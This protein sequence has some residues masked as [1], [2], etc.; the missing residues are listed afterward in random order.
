MFILC[1][2]MHTRRVL[3]ITLIALCAT[4]ASASATDFIVNTVTSDWPDRLRGD[5]Y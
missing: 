4:A 3:I 1:G 2:G 5:G